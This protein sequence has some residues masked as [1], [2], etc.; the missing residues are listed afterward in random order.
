[1]PLAHAEISQLLEELTAVWRDKGRYGVRSGHFGAGLR[2]YHLTTP[3]SYVMLKALQ[4]K[5]G[6]ERTFVEVAA[7]AAYALARRLAR[8]ARCE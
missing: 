8:R 3:D 2:V 7:G 4:A 6:P 5:S 1:M